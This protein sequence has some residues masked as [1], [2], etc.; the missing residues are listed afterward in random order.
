MMMS[1]EG[2]AAV[3]RLDF[4]KRMYATYAA[5]LCH[6]SPNCPGLSACR[7]ARCS[8]SSISRTSLNHRVQ[9]RLPLP[10]DES[11]HVQGIESLVRQVQA[12]VEESVHGEAAGF[13]SARW[14][15]HWLRQPLPALGGRLPASY[16]HT[17]EGQKLAG[18]IPVMISSGSY[19]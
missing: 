16:L 19:A 18:K 10:V 7:G 9:A 12:M 6:V 1:D 15:G 3:N 17:L 14:F 11:Q 4:H 5:G 2:R 13:D 8:L